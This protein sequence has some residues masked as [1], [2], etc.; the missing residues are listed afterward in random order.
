MKE[1]SSIWIKTKQQDLL[2]VSLLLNKNTVLS[3]LESMKAPGT[4]LN[5]LSHETQHVTW[6]FSVGK[7]SSQVP[8]NSEGI[9]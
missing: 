8:Q 4:F 3:V 9:Y 5:S 2:P 1:G 7:L 6:T